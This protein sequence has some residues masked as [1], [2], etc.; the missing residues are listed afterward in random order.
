MSAFVQ[1]CIRGGLHTM[2]S[3]SHIC[4]ASARRE[5][6]FQQIAQVESAGLPLPCAAGQSNH[7][8]MMWLA[9]EWSRWMKSLHPGAA[10]SAIMERCP[11]SLQSLSS[12]H[13]VSFRLKKTGFLFLKTAIKW[14]KWQQRGI[15]RL[16]SWLPTWRTWSWRIL[17]PQW[18]SLVVRWLAGNKWV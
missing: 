10:W 1:N 11:S 18:P 16:C 12:W 7:D 13:C 8:L 4:L 15:P 6:Y 17:T 14:L 5:R 3:S 2:S 9:W